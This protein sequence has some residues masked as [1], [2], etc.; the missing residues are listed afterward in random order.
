MAVPQ[1][2]LSTLAGVSSVYVIENGAVR[3]QNVTLGVQEGLNY[4]VLD[5]L[6][7]NEILAASS[8]NEITSGMKVTAIEGGGPKNAG[9][10]VPATDAPA[11]DAKPSG[12]GQRRGGGRRNAVGD[13]GNN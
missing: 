7:G 1:E 9:E 2:A 12:K 5:G 6:K 8:L 10:A 11:K 4:E 13:G 3:Q